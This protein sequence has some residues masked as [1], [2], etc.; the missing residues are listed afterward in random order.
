VG[1][2]VIREL[3]VA[4]ASWKKGLLHGGD[5]TMGHPTAVVP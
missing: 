2:A 1:L 5:V 3:E 4:P